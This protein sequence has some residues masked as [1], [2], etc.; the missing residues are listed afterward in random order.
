MTF[1]LYTPE[2]QEIIIPLIDFLD[3]IKSKNMDDDLSWTWN[4]RARSFTYIQAVTLEV[5]F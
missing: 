1:K 2:V 3:F 5:L 4:R